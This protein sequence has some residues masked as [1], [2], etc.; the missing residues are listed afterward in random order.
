[1]RKILLSVTILLPILFSMCSQPTKKDSPQTS[2]ENPLLAEYKTPFE[3]PP[4]DKIKVEHFLPAV[5]EAIS[6][7][8][9]EVEAIVKN[10]ETPTFQNTIEALDFSGR[11]LTN[12]ME[13]A[14]NLQGANTNDSLQKVM[15]EISPLVTQHGDNISLNPDL[16]KRVKVIYDSKEKSNLSTEQMRLLEKTYKGFVRNGAGLDA[17][18]QKRMREINKELSLAGL[19]FSE[20]L[21]A[22]TNAFKL[23]IEKKEDLLGLPQS[24]VDAA[25][26]AA[27][28]NKMDGKWVFSLHN[29]SLM[30]FLQYADNRDLR[31]KIWKA[32]T[33]RGNNNNSNDNKQIIK[34]ITDLRC[35]KSKLLGYKSFADFVLDEN[36]AKTPEKVLG[37]LN[38]LWTPAL[39]VA[40]NE[41]KELQALMD[42][43]GKKF[44]LEPWD[45]R[46]YAEKL[47]K[48]KYDLDEE[49][50]RPYFVLENVKNGA[51]EVCN[52]LYGIK[53]IEKKDIPKYHPDVLTYEVQD[54]DG[55]HLGVL[56]MDFYARPSKSGGAWMSN[57]RDQ[58][59]LNGKETRPVITTAFNFPKPTG[60]TPT[61]LT[62]DEVT[63]LYH[64]LGHALHGLLTKCTYPGL[65]G[66]TVARDFVELPSQIMESWASEPE[67]LKFYAKH[68]QTGAIIPNE[69]I[70]K[71]KKSSQFN[72][73]FTTTEYLAASLLDMNY[74]VL[75]DGLKQDAVEF[76][77]NILTK[78]GLIP[79]ILVRYRST[80]FNHI[81][82]PG[83]EYAAGYYGYIW[84]E[85][86]DADAFEFFQKNGIFDQKTAAAFRNNVLAKGGTEN[87]MILYKQFRGEEP[88]PDAL[89]RRRGLTGN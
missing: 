80:Y 78:A 6:R 16:F 51:F 2:G 18:K 27:K 28:E 82:G 89:L 14:T 79:E 44:K 46:Y 34:Q 57:Y 55:S 47:R 8:E 40:K 3:V 35:E 5:K 48:A 10:A 88:K 64:E 62:F 23:I 50:L 49:Q 43:E 60:N 41:A 84:A 19:K 73:G 11:M 25:A 83:G 53:F 29:P 26:E 65:S 9:K 72:Q 67:V 15:Q 52:R 75:T 17:E 86:L 58:F 32:Y 68:Y 4:F 70:E 36:M 81:F 74:Q 76:E 71:I 30:P 33:N 7:H 21:L 45:W 66:T 59:V 54:S 85:V 37:F 20:N 77:K 42:K 38:S 61:L 39:K 1:M 24:I 63:T 13:T 87:P 22:E 56:L 69:L 31:E 12:I